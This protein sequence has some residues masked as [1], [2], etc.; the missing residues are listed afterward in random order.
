MDV[1]VGLVLP[2]HVGSSLGTPPAGS[3]LTVSTIPFLGSLRPL[4]LLSLSP[5]SQG[6][7]SLKTIS[8]MT[9]QALGGGWLLEGGAS[10]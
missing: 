9:S 1:F 5:W 7:L 4:P 8:S 3:T 2:L 10:S 6:T